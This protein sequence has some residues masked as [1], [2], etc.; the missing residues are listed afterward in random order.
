MPWLVS[1]PQGHPQLSSHTAPCQRAFCMLNAGA[2]AGRLAAKRAVSPPRARAGAVPAAALLP[3]SLEQRACVHRVHRAAARPAPGGQ[4]GR[5]RQQ[6]RAQQQCPVHPRQLPSRRALPAAGGAAAVPRSG[7]PRAHYQC[8]TQGLLKRT[9]A[10]S[11][12]RKKSEPDMEGAASRHY[13]LPVK[14]K[15][16]SFDIGDK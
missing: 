8:T 12:L 13:S 14:H 11:E 15:T 1:A 6:R 2:A 7:A 5:R 4:C 3:G 16:I 9:C 10:L